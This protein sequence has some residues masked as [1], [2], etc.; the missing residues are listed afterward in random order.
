[1]EYAAFL[2]FTIGATPYYWG[3]VDAYR[4]GHQ[5]DGV[6][7]AWPTPK[8]AFPDAFGMLPIQQFDISV[9]SEGLLS[10]PLDTDLIGAEVVL[11]LVTTLRGESLLQDEAGE[12]LTDEAGEF[13]YDAQDGVIEHAITKT[14][15]IAACRLVPGVLTLTLADID[16]SALDA[17]YPIHTWT[18]DDWPELYVDDV[19]KP[20]PVSVGYAMRVPAAYLSNNSGAGPWVYG[21]GEVGTGS[22]VLTVYRD[23]R[24]I[25]PAEYY[26]GTDSAAEYDTIT[27][28]FGLEQADPSGHL[29]QIEADIFSGHSRNAAKELGRIMVAAGLSMDV[30]S[31]AAA[32]AQC[33]SMGAIVDC[34]YVDPRTFRAISDDLCI[35]LRG[36]IFRTASG[37]MGIA[38]DVAGEPQ[39]TLNEVEGDLIEVQ[40]I[41]VPGR[42]ATSELSYKPRPSDP[43]SLMHTLSRDAGGVTGVTHVDMP[44]IS[45]HT[46]ADRL[47][48][49]LALRAQYA[50]RLRMVIAQ[51]ELHIGDIISITS[52]QFWSGALEWRITSLQ[53]QPLGAAC[54]LIQYD[55]AIHVYSAGTLPSDATTGYLPDYSQTPPRAPT[56][57]TVDDSDATVG[58][59]GTVTAWVRVYATPPAVNWEQM[60]FSAEDDDSGE[61]FLAQ[62][63]DAGDGTWIAT[64]TG[65]RPA[66]DFTLRS[67][68]INSSGVLGEETLGVAHT[69][70]TDAS[71]PATPTGLAAQQS[72]GTG[73]RVYWNANTE[74]DLAYYQVQVSV[75]GGAYADL[76]QV[77]A[78]A[79]SG[80]RVIWVNTGYAYGTSYAFKVSA[81]DTS[82]NES[83]QA[84]P[85]SVTPAANVG[86]TDITTGGV[87]TGNIAGSAVTTPKRQAV[88]TASQYLSIAPG[89]NSISFSVSVSQV[90][91]VT[92][93]ITPT[94][95]MICST[96]SNGISSIVVHVYSFLPGSVSCTVSIYYW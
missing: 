74:A 87:G 96:V 24:I 12:A 40:E 23:G 59:T 2:S 17:T 29:Y 48:C 19:G 51:D 50:A 81:L 53:R 18:T 86:G 62:G 92:T 47:A 26:I 58:S 32:T 80:N 49:Y 89:F 85:A 38:Q 71:V 60:W 13:L 3:S 65:L 88:N 45:D 83:P 73:I 44:Y 68:A 25:D 66:A 69:S 30:P 31:A 42:P 1:V 5:Y 61:I 27:I 16:A 75:N 10:L 43:S 39:Y 11:S 52:A 7:T 28:G 34:R 9:A 37:A 21:A 55:D 91:V 35:V 14:V 41:D 20:V 57:L 90:A 78:S 6:L 33:A 4:D 79:K 46:A 82:G 22:Q 76:A 67:R 77:S 36:Y 63:E 64:I 8:D 54:E 15:N 70:A 84:G 72:T 56:G 95:G 94:T 93:A